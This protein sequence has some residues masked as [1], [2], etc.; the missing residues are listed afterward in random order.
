MWKTRAQNAPARKMLLKKQP[1][2]AKIE[3]MP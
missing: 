3:D 2:W 1:V